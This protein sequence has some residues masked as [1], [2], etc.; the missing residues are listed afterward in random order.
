M[1]EFFLLTYIKS[2]F[3]DIIA[4]IVVSIL[5]SIFTF[6]ISMKVENKFGLYKYFLKILHKFSEIQIRIR[7]TYHSSLPFNYIKDY[8]KN[9]FRNQYQ[10]LKVYKDSSE[11]LDFLVNNEFHVIVQNDSNNELSVY[12][13]KITTRVNKSKSMVNNFLKVL[14]NIKEK[15][16]EQ[17]ELINLKE[18]D[19]SLFLDLPYED[20]FSTIYVPK[21]MTKMKNDLEFINEKNQGTMKIN[22]NKVSIHTKRSD[23]L[24]EIIEYLV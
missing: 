14:E 13:N 10:N 11:T 16:H 4:S 24:Y 12:T 5:A 1:T 17:N 7:V 8:A 18:K 6:F 19:F 2:L 21:N 22:G 20:P 23:D 15:I 9:E 3:S